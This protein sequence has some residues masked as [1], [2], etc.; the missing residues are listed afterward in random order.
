MDSNDKERKVARNHSLFRA[1]KNAWHGIWMVLVRERNMRIH[2][3]FAFIILVAG[4]HFG[5]NRADWLWATIA[6]FLPV[7]SE[8]LNTIIESVVDLI[9]DKEYHPLAGLAKDV[10]AGV[11]FVAVGFELIILF[12][13]F[14]PYVWREFGIVTH[15][16]EYIHR[17]KG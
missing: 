7:Y 11:V 6:V 3:L 4:L 16:S 15:F 13:I 9:V 17:F 8:F 12:I 5:L 10:A 1:M 14:Q 2:I